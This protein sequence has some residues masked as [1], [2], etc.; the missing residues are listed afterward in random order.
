M[1]EPCSCEQ[2]SEIVKGYMEVM[3]ETSLEAI[4]FALDQK[5][6]KTSSKKKTGEGSP[7]RGAYREH[8]STCL[9]EV[10]GQEPD[11]KQ[12][13][14]VCAARWREKKQQAQEQ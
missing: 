11:P 4:Q 9:K 1:A 13:I 2:I 5:D 14:S 6:S 10:K 8:M 7:A 12:R 3:L